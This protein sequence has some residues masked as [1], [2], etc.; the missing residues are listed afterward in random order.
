MLVHGSFIKLFVFGISFLV[1][2]AIPAVA[3]QNPESPISITLSNVSL[4]EALQE[5][6]KKSGVVFSYNPKKI[7]ATEKITYRAVNKS[8]IA[9]LDDFSTAYQL[10]YQQVENQIVL[11]PEKKITGTPVTQ[12]PATI[13]GYVKDQQ[14]GEALIG[15]GVFVTELKIGTTTNSYGYY[16]LTLPK[17]N[18]T[19]KYS[20]V[21]FKDLVKQVSLTSSIQRDLALEQDIPELKEVV[22][23][24]ALSRDLVSEIQL[25]KININP[26]SIE[27][28]P[29][30]FGELDVI[31]SLESIPG[32]KMH[33]DGSTFYSVRGGNRDQNLVM[34]DDAP[35]YNPS[36]LLGLFSTIIPD[37]VNDI[38]FYKGDMPAS[39]GGRLSSVLDIRTKKGN[40]QHFQAWGNFGLISTKLGIEGPFK[41]SAS[42]Y[43]LSTRISRLKWIMQL[44]DNNVKQF[45]FADVTAKI[46]VKLNASNRV[47]LS[48]YTG[49]DN[50][51]A[52]NSGI[53]WS[54]TALTLRWNHIFSERLFLNT[55]FSGSNY[56]YFLHTNVDAGTRW[57]SKIA[58][59]SMKSD[60]SY[61]VNPESEVTF[62][63]GIQGFGFNPGNVQSSAATTLPSLS[64]KNSLE[65][66]L[67]ANHEIR[68]NESWGLNYGV[69]MSSWINNGEAFEFSFDENHNAV[70][71]TYY[72][73][74]QSYKSF[75][76]AEPRISLRR[77]LNE[78]SSVKFSYAKNVQNIHLI[79]NSI[80]PFTSLEVWLPSSVN[81][82]PEVAD[83]LSLGYYRTFAQ[84][85]IA[86]S[87]EAFYKKMKN[88]IDYAP[89]AET[90]L[91]PQLEGELR[92][93]T[94]TAH[95]IELLAKKDEG[96][97]RGWAG[98]TFSRSKR[99]FRELNEGRSF[100]SFYDRPHQIN[101]MASYDL[102]L[103][104]N[105][106]MTWVYT[107]GAPY[108]APISFYEFNGE[109][110]PIYGQRN[111]ERLPDYHRLDLSAKYK[112]NRNPEKKYQH[113]LSFSIFNFYGRK[114]ILFVNYHKTETANGD[115]QVPT[116]L[117]DAERVSTQFY[118]FQF[119][120]SLS[121][122]FRWR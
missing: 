9:I 64:V 88:Q 106:G 31:K 55:T 27:E 103:R 54:N 13:S 74:G 96:R 75:G 19:L 72:T 81:I 104:W 91:N 1:L 117:L 15:S 76:R 24:D 18:Y 48:F 90:L 6:A 70:D 58:N 23:T 84:F 122:N 100:N 111:N 107:T 115:F 59:L 29:S 66:F 63:T 83:Q 121:Y 109:E 39:F 30:F 26:L 50:Y 7:P 105:V 78:L 71:T 101:V 87:A 98:Y 69:R 56:D 10:N 53:A 99:K 118:L 47:Y 16:S 3:Q 95:G 79:S 25:G 38:N 77:S 14:T 12:L 112:L 49:G 93:G 42:S 68:F 73:A 62:G 108:S 2:I 5:I 22:V 8:V 92:F 97:L 43:L 82:Q 37:A 119:T 89:H 113:D 32:V 40:D 35:I 21:G 11:K 110:V 94:G 34:I 41:K 45:N 36:H 114:N 46:N 85:G 61:F 60:F 33:S 102:S 65:L 17:G 57:N 44:R 51:F 116:N 120:P 4:A 80:S 52:N 20:F 28:R 67:Y 86:F